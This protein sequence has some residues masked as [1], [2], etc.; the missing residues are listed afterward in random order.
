MPHG[1]VAEIDAQ[2]GQVDRDIGHRR[3]VAAGIADMARRAPRILYKR[4]QPEAGTAHAAQSGH[5][6]DWRSQ[7]HL[8]VAPHAG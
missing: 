3:L 5:G 7:F 6:G 4:A 1:A 2:P 8:E